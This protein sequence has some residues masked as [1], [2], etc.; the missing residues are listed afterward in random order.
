[1][2]QFVQNI[3]IERVLHKIIQIVDYVAI[4]THT[5]PNHLD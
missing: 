2:R 5:H 4:R 1:M 3:I